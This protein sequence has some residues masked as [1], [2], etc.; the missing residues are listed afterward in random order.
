[1]RA[2]ASYGEAFPG[3]EDYQAKDLACRGL[4]G[5]GCCWSIRSCLRPAH[6]V[7]G[8]VESRAKRVIL[9]PRIVA[10]SFLGHSSHFTEHLL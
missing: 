10:A 2:E 6:G 5:L 1:M 3:K 7:F 9:A 8:L 4:K